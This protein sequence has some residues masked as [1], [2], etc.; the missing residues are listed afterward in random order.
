MTSV[1]IPFLQ[2]SEPPSLAAMRGGQGGAPQ[3]EAGCVRFVTAVDAVGT[4]VGNPAAFVEALVGAAVSLEIHMEHCRRHRLSM[5]PAVASKKA[6][7]QSRLA[8]V[9]APGVFP[10]AGLHNAQLGELS[11]AL[12]KLGVGSAMRSVSAELKERA[13]KLATLS[14]TA[15]AFEPRESRESR[16]PRP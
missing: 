8:A 1:T 5:H 2:E 11:S 4:P 9:L 15:P 14:A 13:R 6:E 3:C 10:F 7:L 16:N 12:I